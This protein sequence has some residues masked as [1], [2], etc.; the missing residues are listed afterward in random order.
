[1]WR[2]VGISGPPLKK[3]FEKSKSTSKMVGIRVKLFLK[4]IHLMGRILGQRGPG[5]TRRRTPRIG[6][7]G[8]HEKKSEESAS[9][10]RARARFLMA[11]IWIIFDF[12]SFLIDSTLF[13]NDFSKNDSKMSPNVALLWVSALHP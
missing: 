6:P 12:S 8:S 7:K 5:H 4:S 9:H 11:Y 10:H 3:S 2:S 13:L 1:M